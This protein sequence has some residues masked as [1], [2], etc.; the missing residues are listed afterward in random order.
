MSL[1]SDESA[2]VISNASAK[3]GE[4]TVDSLNFSMFAGFGSQIVG[5]LFLFAQPII[6]CARL[7]LKTLL[8]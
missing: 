2:F 3:F 7:P 1:I 6:L 8:L 4:I 5:I